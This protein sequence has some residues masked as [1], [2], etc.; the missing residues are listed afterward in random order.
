MRDTTLQ[1]RAFGADVTHLEVKRDGIVEALVVPYNVPAPV[2]EYNEVLRE[3]VDYREQFVPGAFSRAQAAPHRV[4][5]TFTHSDL[6]PDRMGYGRSVRDSAEGAVVEWQ[7]YA[8][9]REQATELLE[10]THQQFSVTFQTIRPQYGTERSGQLV[11]REAVHLSSVAA[12]D[13]PVYV[14]T[15]VLAMRDQ[16]DVQRELRQAEQAK[17]R[18]QVETILWLQS[19]GRELS[20]AQLA[21]L[22]QHRALV[23]A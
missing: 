12:T 17:A 5:L 20:P 13:N 14:D 3:V 16:Q 4:G 8:Y 21:Y 23:T 22:E 18:R 11:T 19:R 7:L 1:L 15:R 9:A 2:L 6:M 10:T